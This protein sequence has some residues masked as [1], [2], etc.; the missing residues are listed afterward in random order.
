MKSLL[1]PSPR[2]AAATC[3]SMSPACRYS[4]APITPIA[5]ST[6]RRSIFRSAPVPIKRRQIRVRPLHRIRARQGLVGRRSSGRP[7]RVQFRHRPV[8]ILSR[9]QRR[10]RRVHRPQLSLPRGVHRAGVVDALRFSGDQG[11]SRQARDA[12]RRDAVRRAG[13]VHQHAPRQVR[14][15]ARA[16]GA[17]LRLRLRV[18]Q[19]DHHVWR[20]CAHPFAVSEL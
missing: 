10:L 5:T 8:R 6:N 15:S 20:L 2:S 11:W 7:R 17:V 9:S 3:R 19:Q 14:R 1:S 4:R 13:L 12:A 16:R 18:D